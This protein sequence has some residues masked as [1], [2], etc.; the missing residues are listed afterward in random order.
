[1]HP[2]REAREP[3]GERHPRRCWQRPWSSASRRSGDTGRPR[4]PCGLRCEHQPGQRRVP[5]GGG[6]EWRERLCFPGHQRSCRAEEGV[7]WGG[8]AQWKGGPVCGAAGSAC[9]E[10]AA[11][12]GV[13]LQPVDRRGARSG[14]S[15][16]GGRVRAAGPSPRR[17]GSGGGP[18]PEG[19]PGSVARP[20]G[21]SGSW[22]RG[23]HPGRW[24]RPGTEGQHGG[25]G[26]GVLGGR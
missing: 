17:A 20:G 24:P 4:G 21:P 19:L 5:A 14:S 18:G 22:M 9:V 7:S 8:C 11:A 2:A 3:P 10:A 25:L 6:G 12:V 15:S 13:H 16:A 23:R 1:M 26:A